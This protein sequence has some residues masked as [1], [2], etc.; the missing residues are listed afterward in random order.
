[1][2]TW[3]GSVSALRSSAKVSDLTFRAVAPSPGC[4]LDPP[5]E[6]LHATA[7]PWA[8]RTPEQRQCRPVEEDPGEPVRLNPG[9]FAKLLSGC[10]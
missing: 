3:P 2:S 7:T 6:L 10:Q 1:M 8:P 4:V 9:E 5:G